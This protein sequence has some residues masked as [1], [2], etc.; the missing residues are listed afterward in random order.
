MKILDKYI[1]KELI[2][3][4]LFGIFGYI[5]IMSVDPLIDVV[6]YI[7]IRKAPVFSVFKWYV[8]KVF[9]GNMIYSFSMAS[10]LASFLVFGRLSKDGEINAILAGGI[11]FFRMLKSV[12]IFGTITTAFAWI[13]F[14]FIAPYTN[15][16]YKKIEN[17]EILLL[18][19]VKKLKKDIIIRINKNTF[20]YT[21]KVVPRG[22]RINN[23]IIFKLENKRISEFI[24]AKFAI[25][26]EHKKWIFYNGNVIKLDT[27]TTEFESQEH[28]YQKE[29]NVLKNISLKDLI[30]EDK[31]EKHKFRNINIIKLKEIIKD[32]ESRGAINI[33]EYY[34]E[35][36]LKFS[37]P[38]ASLIFCLIGASMGVYYK[39]S[40]I[41]IGLGL[42]VII[43]FVYYVIISIAKS[44]GI[45]GK[46]NPWIASWI[47]NILFV[48]YSIYFI[49]KSN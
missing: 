3:P 36:Y 48:L 20:L 10:L 6:Q 38:V 11:S 33:F 16:N 5:I 17:T 27:K 35:Y 29:I 18:P 23:C 9:S 25:F 30:K 32:L 39:K 49:K 40:G 15:N 45:S 2:A 14:N 4:F 37:L 26:N 24:A 44:F 8:F 1:L 43:V 21:K 12:L 19:E 34:V 42:S 7:F 46:L 13:F 41:M 31:K 47:A 22:N 28:F